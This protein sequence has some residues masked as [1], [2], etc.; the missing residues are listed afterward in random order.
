M[1]PLINKFGDI[2]PEVSY[3]PSVISVYIN[4]KGQ[5]GNGIASTYATKSKAARNNFLCTE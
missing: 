3:L 5:Y 2:K 1:D 4:L